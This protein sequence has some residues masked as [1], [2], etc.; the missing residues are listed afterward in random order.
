[1]VQRSK[2]K[3]A[4]TPLVVD[5]PVIQRVCNLEQHITVP[6]VHKAE[7]GF[8]VYR[9]RFKVGSA[10]MLVCVSSCWMCCIV[11]VR[12][13]HRRL[14]QCQCWLRS[15]AVRPCSVCIRVHVLNASV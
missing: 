4:S 6:D 3:M 12:L 1:M 15:V 10:C 7:G 14:R 9:I 2:F 13:E 5:H 11:C 8:S